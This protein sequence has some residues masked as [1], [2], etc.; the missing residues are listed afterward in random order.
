MRPASPSSVSAA[1]P[2][3]GIVKSRC[4]ATS[5]PGGARA[6]GGRRPTS[7]RT[8]GSPSCR[9]AVRGHDHRDVRRHREHD[10]AL[11]EGRPQRA[12]GPPSGASQ[13]RP[14][15]SR[16]GSAHLVKQMGVQPVR[17]IAGCSDDLVDRPGRNPQYGSS[18]ATVATVAGVSA[19]GRYL[20]TA[21]KVGTRPEAGRLPAHQHRLRAGDAF[22]RSRQPDPSRD[23]RQPNSTRDA[24]GLGDT[25]FAP[26]LV[27]RV[28][29]AGDR[30][31]ACAWHVALLSPAVPLMPSVARWLL[32]S[33][34][35]GWQ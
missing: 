6:A 34:R 17:R 10:V 35:V 2:S 22:L 9:R 4:N 28:R 21:L 23:S 1:R 25:R 13:S 15:F 11:A 20:A 3:A 24:G 8:S 19:S 32:S 29:P 7:D 33:R 31:S 18:A 12:L 14:W 30:G 27:E 16:A 5:R 26:A